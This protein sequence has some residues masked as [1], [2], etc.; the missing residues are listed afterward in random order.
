MPQLIPAFNVQSLHKWE[1]YEH[2]QQT[3]FM[4]DELKRLPEMAGPKFVFAHFLVPHPPFIFAPDGE[5]AWAEVKAEGYVSN[6]KF[7]DS[8]IV[9]VVAE[10]I[11]KSRLP[12]VI[13][14][15]G[16]HGATGIPR[17]G[18]AAVAHVH[19]E[20]LLRQRS[21]KEGLVR[22]DHPCQQFSGCVQQLF[23][24]RLSIIGRSQ[25]SLFQYEKVYREYLIKNECQASPKS[26][27][28]ARISIDIKIQPQTDL[29]L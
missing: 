15:M 24:N 11:K 25:L 16:D 10:I 5:F 19:S 29:R 3:Y 26:I 21:G 6:V 22:N 20:C 2:Y 8:Q 14:M 9:P 4:L 18:D 7:I 17:V 23:R 27:L 12:P 13:I 28:I 1:Y